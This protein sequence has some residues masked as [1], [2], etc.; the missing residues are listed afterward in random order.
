MTQ[1]GNALIDTIRISPLRI[2]PTYLPLLSSITYLMSRLRWQLLHSTWNYQPTWS[3]APVCQLPS[4]RLSETAFGSSL[5]GLITHRLQIWQLDWIWIQWLLII[6]AILH[7]EILILGD[8]QGSRNL[9]L[10]CGASN[11]YSSQSTGYWIST[12]NIKSKCQNW[13]TVE[14]KI[15]ALTTSN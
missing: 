7:L 11:K 8:S 5:I 9:K 14:Q 13:T 3:G 4:C 12:S 6:L 10:S 15:S 2:I 1:G